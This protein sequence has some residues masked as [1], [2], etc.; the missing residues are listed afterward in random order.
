MKLQSQQCKGGEQLPK[1]KNQIKLEFMSVADN[2]ALARVMVAAFAAQEEMT[3]TDLEEIKVAVSEAVSNS[4]I[5]G[6]ENNPDG[7]VILTA[8]LVDGAV[9]I[10][11]E[12]RG[13]G[14]ADVEQAVQPS[15]STDPDRMGLGFA[16]MQSLMDEF[17][18]ESRVGEGTRVS[19]VRKVKLG[20]SALAEASVTMGG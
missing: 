12:D 2:V 13:K 3:L 17:T 16:F 14:I 19:M 20:V 18:V 11:V 5:H 9:E 10:V 6:Y 7:L 15:F 1:I 8:R 4:I